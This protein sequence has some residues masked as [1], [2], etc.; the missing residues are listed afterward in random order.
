MLGKARSADQF[1][2]FGPIKPLSELSGD[3]Y[4]PNGQKWWEHWCAARETVCLYEKEFYKCKR[5]TWKK[6]TQPFQPTPCSSVVT[7]PYP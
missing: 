7:H 6:C 5:K 2:V 1:Y 4:H 3:I